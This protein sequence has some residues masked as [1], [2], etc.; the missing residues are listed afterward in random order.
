MSGDYAAHGLSAIPFQPAP[1]EELKATI[2]KAFELTKKRFPNTPIV[3]AIGNNDP[4]W[5]NQ[6]ALNESADYYNFLYNLWFESHPVRYPNLNDIKSTFLRGGFYRYFYQDYVFVA[7][8]SL[9]FYKGTE[10]EDHH[11]LD[12]EQFSFL[13]TTLLQNPE[14]RFVI[15]FH[16]NPATYWTFTP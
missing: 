5:H 2:A 6:F 14:K 7:L 10:W 16:F 13:E 15:N 11:G 4:K 9:Y 1:Y 12:L 8:N 3:P